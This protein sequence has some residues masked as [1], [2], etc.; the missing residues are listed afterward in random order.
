VNRR[1][2]GHLVRAALFA[3]FALYV[4]AAKYAPVRNQPYEEALTT[5]TIRAFNAGYPFHVSFDAGN[6]SAPTVMKMSEY[7]ADYGVHILLSLTGSF[8]RTFI[9]PSF[10]LDSSM[11]RAILLWFFLLAA[12]AMLAPPVPLAVGAAAVLSLL[13]LFVWGTLGLYDARYWGVAFVAVVGMTYVATALK[14]WTGWRFGVLVALAAFAGYA[15]LLRQEAGPA[16]YLTGLALAGAAPL[17][18][19][20]SLRVQAARDTTPSP[21]SIAVRAL[22]GGLLLI[23]VNAA[24]LPLERWVFSRAWGTP[25]SETTIAVHGSGWPLYLSLGYISNPFNIGWRD[26]IGEIHA[27]L[28][29]PEIKLNA[30]PIFQQTLLE[31]FERIVFTRPWLLIRNVLA[32]GARVHELANHESGA[33]T[34]TIVPQ[35]YPL[36]LAYRAAPWVMAALLVLLVVRGRPE[37]VVVWVSSAVAAIGAS[38]G[39]VLVFP[40]YIGGVQ[41]ATVALLLVA[42]AAVVSLLMLEQPDSALAARAARWLLATYGVVAVAGVVAGAAFVGVQAWRY[43]SVQAEIAAG[44]PLEGL[45]SQGF[46]YAHVFNDL[47]L[48]RQGRLIARL[49]ASTDENVAHLIDERLGNADLFAPQVLVRMPTEIHVFVWMGRGFVPPTPRLFQGSTHASLFI[50]AGCPP[51]ASINDVVRLQSRWT[52]INDLEWQGRYRMFSVQTLPSFKDVRFFRIAAER[53]RALDTSLPTWMVP[54]LIASAR[55]GF[56]ESQ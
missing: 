16:T 1:W 7:Y 6:G 25:F 5:A 10:R 8:G 14:P 20:A 13:A 27:R 55:V 54:E 31:E 39:A 35:P 26:P 53:T 23:C 37:G 11:V 46:R 36:V 41:G 2:I 17:V 9:S 50:C 4:Y 18:G 51:T 33:N 48:T 22:A 29:N 49:Q 28:I 21:R 56:A 32:K 15:R 43:R 47:P 19:L 44:D 34:G 38:A 24:I 45:R 30:D 3:V 40:E 42:P 12:A 52:M